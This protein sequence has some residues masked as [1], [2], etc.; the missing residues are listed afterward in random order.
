MMVP[1]IQCIVD[2]FREKGIKIIWVRF[3]DEPIM[4]FE[5]RE[6]EL[7]FSKTGMG[8][9]SN[10]NFQEVIREM[11]I[12]TL[13]FTGVLT[14]HCVG[15]SMMQAKS[16]GFQTIVV[17]DATTDLRLDHYEAALKILGLHG[18]RVKTGQV[19]KEY[20]WTNWVDTDPLP[21]RREPYRRKIDCQPG[22]H[23]RLSQQRQSTYLRCNST[24]GTAKHHHSYGQ[25]PQCV[26]LEPSGRDVDY[27]YEDGEISLML[28]VLEMH[29]VVVVE[30]P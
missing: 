16:A 13:M 22:Q 10:S 23:K 30:W 14:S 9:F 21:V 28:P 25:K 24:G 1:N 5:P 19:L 11:G 29:V 6:D 17:D 12:N 20:P 18:L 3:H 4:Y 2:L 27:T 26:T 15:T 7:V 8:V